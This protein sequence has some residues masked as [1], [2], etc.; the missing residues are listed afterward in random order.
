MSKYLILYTPTENIRL[1]LQQSHIGT[2]TT[3]NIK[4]C[5]DKLSPPN[6]GHHK[7]IPDATLERSRKKGKET[8]KTL[9]WPKR[10][11]VSQVAL[12]KKWKIL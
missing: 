9:H 11:R 8:Q 3:K 12:K 5:Q 2:K 4:D 1:L 10:G 6:P 7:F